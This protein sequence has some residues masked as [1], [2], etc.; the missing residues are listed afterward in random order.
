M[1]QLY[2][3]NTLAT[4]IHLSY[5]KFTYIEISTVLVFMGLVLFKLLTNVALPCSAFL[6][7]ALVCFPCTHLLYSAPLCATLIFS[8]CYVPHNSTTCLSSYTTPGQ[9]EESEDT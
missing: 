9:W 1:L 3:I 8:R 7:A 6:F 5:E 4:L 2:K